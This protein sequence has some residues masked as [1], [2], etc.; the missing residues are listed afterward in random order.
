MSAAGPGVTADGY[1]WSCSEPNDAGE[2]YIPNV[3]DKEYRDVASTER[4]VIN[5]YKVEGLT[6][7]CYGTEVTRIEYCYKHDTAMDG[8]AVFNWTVLILQDRNS[9]LHLIRTTMCIED[10][11]CDQTEVTNIRLS[12]SFY[13]GVT[14]STQGNTHNAAL[15]GYHESIPMYSVDAIQLSINGLS[16]GLSVGSTI[17]TQSSTILRGLRMLW[18]VTGKLL[19]LIE[20]CM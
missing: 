2:R 7:D 3:T 8:Y 14:E 18:F 13:F 12:E 5:I 10:G 17:N 16:H 20:V 6:S 9:R 1:T 19:P 15:L 11:R 4:N